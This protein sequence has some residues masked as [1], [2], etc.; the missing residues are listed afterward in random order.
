MRPIEITVDDKQLLEEGIESIADE[1]RAAFATYGRRPE[2][3][4]RFADGDVHEVT[5]GAETAAI[6]DWSDEDFDMDCDLPRLGGGTWP[7]R[8]HLSVMIR[9]LR[10]ALGERPDG[11]TW[12]LSNFDEHFTLFIATRGHVETAARSA[13]DEVI[14]D[15]D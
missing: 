3:S 1:L 12:Q 15:F 2:I 10:A 11:A 6:A 5:I 8:T 7:C 14:Y 13:N 9:L 4:E